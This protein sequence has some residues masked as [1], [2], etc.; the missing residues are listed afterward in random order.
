MEDIPR[1]VAV[2]YSGCKLV[3][4]TGKNPVNSTNVNVFKTKWIDETTMPRDGLLNTQRI[5]CIF[6]CELLWLSG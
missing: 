2:Y 3:V 1:I 5:Q 6:P 4:L